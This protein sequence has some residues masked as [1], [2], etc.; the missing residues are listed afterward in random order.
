MVYRIQ[1]EVLAAKLPI[2]LAEDPS[3]RRGF[4]LVGVGN[5]GNASRSARRLAAHFCLGDPTMKTILIAATAACALLA[6]PALAQAQ[7]SNFYASAGYTSVNVE[8]DDFDVS[9]GAVEGRVGM[10]FNPYVSIEAEAAVGVSDDTVTV[11]IVDVDVKLNYQVGAYVV[12]SYP[13]E[14]RLDLFVRLGYV[15]SEFEADAGLGSVSDSASDYAVGVGAKV[16]F[17]DKDGVRL[18]WTRLGSDANSWSLSYV[19]EF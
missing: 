3:G 11:G 1:P 6:V 9:L 4:L 19:R 12:L 18:D 7:E 16:S 14:E 13:A 10:Q 17:T 5:A 2:A 8:S 15:T